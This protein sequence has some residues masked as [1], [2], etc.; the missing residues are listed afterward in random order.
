MES[1]ESSRLTNQAGVLW[2]LH[3]LESYRK[4]LRE[5]SAVQEHSEQLQEIYFIF[6]QPPPLTASLTESHRFLFLPV[7]YS[8]QFKTVLKDREPLSMLI[9]N[10]ILLPV[11]DAVTNRCPFGFYSEKYFPQLNARTFLKLWS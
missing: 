6:Y 3:N 8:V 9:L 11:Q 4:S 7:C 10:E 5:G 2:F 1:R